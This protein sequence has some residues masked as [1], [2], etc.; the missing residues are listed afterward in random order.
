MSLR[1]KRQTTYCSYISWY[2]PDMASGFEK[3]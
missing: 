3:S 2:K 1:N